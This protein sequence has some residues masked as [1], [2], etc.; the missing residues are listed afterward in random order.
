GI[1]ASV[2]F[3]KLGRLKQKIMPIMVLAIIFC[4]NL[5]S[6]RNQTDAVIPIMGVALI[7]AAPCWLTWSQP[8]YAFPVIPLIAVFSFVL[9]D[10]FLKRSW[11]QVLAPVL[12][13]SARRRGM[14]FTLAFFFCIQI[15]WIVLILSW[16]ARTG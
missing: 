16:G 3:R 9:L 5:P 2:W 15:E 6:F 4:F 12:R 7:Y 13:S 11:R 10:A 14:V 8:R 1:T